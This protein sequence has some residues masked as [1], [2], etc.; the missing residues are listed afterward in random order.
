M[1]PFGRSTQIDRNLEC[2]SGKQ[3]Y[4][5]LSFLRLPSVLKS[6]SDAFQHFLINVKTG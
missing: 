5:L 6:K 4:L 1:P 3:L 2:L